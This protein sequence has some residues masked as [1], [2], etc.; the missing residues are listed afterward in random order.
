MRKL[1]NVIIRK[2][3]NDWNEILIF[4]INKHTIL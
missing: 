4:G 3:D 1:E 2:L